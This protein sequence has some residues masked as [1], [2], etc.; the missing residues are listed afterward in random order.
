MF[1]AKIRKI[2]EVSENSGIRRA[3]TAPQQGFFCAAHMCSET[4]WTRWRS[5]REARSGQGVDGVVDTE[6]LEAVVD[7]QVLC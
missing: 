6:L 7:S 2:T 3:M 1:Q 4:V 5:I